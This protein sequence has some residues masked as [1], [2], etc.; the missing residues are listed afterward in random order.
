M[1]CT[2][3][4]I[5]YWPCS[6]KLTEHNNIRIFDLQ[7]FN[8]EKTEDATPKHKEDARKKGQVARSVEINSAFVILAAFLALKFIGPYIYSEL[9]DYMRGMFTG[10]STTDFTIQTV[11]VLFLN[12][13][14]VFLKTSLPVML[15]IVIIGIAISFLQVGFVFSLEPLMPSLSKINPLSGFARLFSMRSMVELVKSIFKIAIITFYIYRFAVN[16]AGRIPD[17]INADLYESLKYTGAL[18]LDLAFQIGAVVLVLAAFDY[19]Y[20]WWEYNKSL[21]MSKYEVKEEFKQTE[22]NPQIKAKIKERQRALAMRRMMQEVPKATAIITNPTHFAVAIKYEKDMPA[23]EVVAKGQDFLAERIKKVA[24]ENSVI[25]IE[26]K[27]LARALF[28]TVEIGEVIP[29]ELYQ[30]VAEV[31]A[32]V[33]RLK[34][35]FS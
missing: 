25:I 35:R 17:L 19:F 1:E 11:Y 30:A 23:P 8:Q 22:G 26:N 5:V 7:L 33:Y 13:A 3:T 20:Q 28:A 18:T 15:A 24:R 16:Q 4:S 31:L 6:S 21:K 14:L 9:S 2:K 32:Y 27:P 10:F 34:K 29:P 12:F